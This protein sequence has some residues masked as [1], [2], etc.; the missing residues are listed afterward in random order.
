MLSGC[1]VV[2]EE[3]PANGVGVGGMGGVLGLEWGEIVMLADPVDRQYVRDL[4]TMGT[5]FD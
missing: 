1:T 2:V 4:L 3:G 5:S